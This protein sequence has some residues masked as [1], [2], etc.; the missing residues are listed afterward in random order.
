MGKIYCTECGNENND[1]DKFCSSCGNPLNSTKTT[2][3][4]KISLDNH[5]II[6]IALIAVIILLFVGILSTGF[7][8]P[9]IPLSTADFGYFEMGIPEGSSFN[10][11]ESIGHLMPQYENTGKYSEDFGLVSYSAKP[12]ETN[13][14]SDLIEENDNMKLY[15]LNKGLQEKSGKNYYELLY[16]KDGMYFDL[17]GENPDL[18][19]QAAETIVVK[20][21]Y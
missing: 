8:T 11:V 7:L 14:A 17:S 9:K 21:N 5:Q 16:E 2:E 1:S 20:N 18:L 10:Q 12:Q 15:E 4:P 3:L 13:V 19:K 6:I